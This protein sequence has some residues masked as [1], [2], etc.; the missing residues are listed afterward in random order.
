MS[1]KKKKENE[2]FYDF[3]KITACIP[4]LVWL[5][6]KRIFPYGKPNMKGPLLVLANH[7]S[8]SDPIT[9]LCSFPSRR[10]HSLATKDLFSNKF[11]TYFFKKMHCIEVDKQ[12][13]SMASFH[14]VV[15]RL[16]DGKA[17]MIFP[18]GSVKGENDE[19]VRSFKSGV[20]LMA[21]K[22][23]APIIPVY[24]APTTRWYQRQ[25]VVIGQ[26]IDISGMLGAIPSVETMTR[27]SEYL[28]EKELALRTYH[29]SKYRRR[30][31][32]ED[33]SPHQTADKEE[34][35]HE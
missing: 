21:H 22:G 6:P 5:R 25:H 19:A 31:G 28:Y 33:K 26:P 4:S 15:S 32:N 10:L 11:L 12:N 24:I 30:H 2:F 9:M 1:T 27:V 34:M 14:E 7:P 23:N 13:F 8:L 16:K 18:E 29:E 20:V 3:V 17:I 35:D